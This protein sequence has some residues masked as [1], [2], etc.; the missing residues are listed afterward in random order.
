[1]LRYFYYFDDNS[2]CKGF[3]SFQRW[4]QV[5]I[6][7][8]L[9]WVEFFMGI[10]LLVPSSLLVLVFFYAITKFYVFRFL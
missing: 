5:P 7:K 4:R 8:F 10:L 3:H 2:L 1:M 9:V 6:H